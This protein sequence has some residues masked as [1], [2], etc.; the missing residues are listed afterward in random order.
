MRV[1]FSSDSFGTDN[2]FKAYYEIRR[3]FKEDVPSKPSKSFLKVVNLL[4][5][6]ATPKDSGAGE[7]DS[8]VY[9]SDSEAGESGFGAGE[10]DSEARFN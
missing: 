8:G 10:S 4:L 9:E 7:S 6:S 1:L 3:A 5:K 2:G